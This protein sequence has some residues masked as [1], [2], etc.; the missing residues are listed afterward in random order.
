MIIE[1]R[2]VKVLIEDY[3]VY[4]MDRYTLELVIRIRHLIKNLAQKF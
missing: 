4:V 3:K 2:V 1:M